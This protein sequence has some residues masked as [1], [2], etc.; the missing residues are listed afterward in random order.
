MLVVWYCCGVMDILPPVLPLLPPLPSSLGWVGWD[1]WRI[2]YKYPLTLPF[3]SL[4]CLSDTGTQ[5]GSG[6]WCPFVHTD[7]SNLQLCCWVLACLLYWQSGSHDGFIPQ[8]VGTLVS[9]LKWQDSKCLRGFWYDI[10]YR[11]C[12]PH[13]HLAQTFGLCYTA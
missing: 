9:P 7:Y 11:G 4:V 5:D 12:K 2:M 10:L 6:L 13:E 3:L 8:W 1:S